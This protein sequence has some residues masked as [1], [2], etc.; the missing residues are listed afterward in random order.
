MRLSSEVGFPTEPSTLLVSEQSI[1]FNVHAILATGLQPFDY[2]MNADPQCGCQLKSLLKGLM[3]R[4][5]GRPRG[6][7]VPGVD[8]FL[9]LRT[10]VRHTFSDALASLLDV[11]TRNA[12]RFRLG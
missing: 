11:C 4:N 7:G 3:P 12:G 9:V 10:Q 5:L 2:S 1:R 8:Q 6:L